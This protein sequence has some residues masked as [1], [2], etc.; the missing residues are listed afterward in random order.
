MLARPRLVNRI[1]GPLV[2]WAAFHELDYT[3]FAVGIYL[4]LWGLYIAYFYVCERCP[5]GLTFY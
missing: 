3:L 2:E 1:K 5:I 4:T